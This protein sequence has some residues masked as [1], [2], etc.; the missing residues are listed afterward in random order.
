MS[1]LLGQKIGMTSVYNEKGD[2][3]PVSVIKAGPCKIV[4]IR[5]KEKDGYHALQLGF[6]E[7]KEKRVSKPVLGQFKKN[8]LAPL[9]VLREF[10]FSSEQEFKIG[11]E[12][13]VSIFA[14]GEKIKVRAK[15]KGKGFQGVMRRHGFGGVGGTTHGQS[16]RL[17][18][19]GSIGASSYPSRVFKGQRMAGRMG[20]KN[21]TISNLK[22]F[23]VIHEQN[24]ILVRGAVPGAINTIVELLKR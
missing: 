5:T 13:N 4:S 16:D 8:E 14:E 11:D 3:V 18:A 21:V 15:S 1:G 17:R 23:K 9:K 19:P 6:G 7:K 22:I 12:I 2:L 24:L 10:K 20:H